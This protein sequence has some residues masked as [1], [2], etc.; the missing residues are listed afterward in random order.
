MAS[1]KKRETSCTNE[2][3]FREIAK[4]VGLKPVDAE[5][6]VKFACIWKGEGYANAHYMTEWAERFKRK[7]EYL[8]ADDDRSA[9]LVE[10]DG[11]KAYQIYR[12]QL[13]RWY[14]SDSNSVMSRLM[15]FARKYG[16]YEVNQRKVKGVVKKKITK[17]V[18]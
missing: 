5:R 17:K 12:D 11:K 1:N 8:C 16:L 7:D 14:G 10:V 2:P 6:F 4:D 15:I 18:K 3:V 9:M 13:I